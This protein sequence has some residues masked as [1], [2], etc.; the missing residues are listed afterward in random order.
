MVETVAAVKENKQ[1]VNLLHQVKEDL[2]VQH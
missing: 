2:S 1:E